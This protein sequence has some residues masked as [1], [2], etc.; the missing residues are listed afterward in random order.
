MSFTE[1][2]DVLDL[3]INILREHEEKLD[4]L[5]DRLEVVSKTIQH[6]PTLR[7][8]LLEYEGGEAASEEMAGVSSIL[9]VDD[10][11]N[12]ANTFKL[13][14]QS[15]GFQVDTAATGLQALYKSNSIKY[16]LVILDMNL[17]DMLGDEVAEKLKEQDENV[18]II[19]I[20]GY[21]SFKDSLDM[22]DLGIDEVLMKPVPPE[23]L[24]KITKKALLAREQ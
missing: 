15:V 17:P 10:D 3:L 4:T 7:K 5:V 1:K 8:T 20:T 14:L 9:V 16:D 11:K 2:I 6:D 22:N 18:N 19:M 13:I 12:L 21:S 23:D 24:V